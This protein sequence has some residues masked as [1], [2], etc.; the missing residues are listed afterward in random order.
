VRINKT[1]ISALLLTLPLLNGYAQSPKPD[2]ELFAK[3]AVKMPLHMA[4]PKLD[5]KEPDVRMYRSRLRDAAANGRMF[6]GHYRAA[7]WG[8]GS[9]C[10][11]FSIID[12][13]T[14]EVYHFPGTISSDNEVGERL[15]FR[16]DSRA[17]HT[18]GSINEGDSA[19]RWYVWNGK[20]FKLI[21]E[22]PSHFEVIDPN[23]SQN[24]R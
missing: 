7:V 20:E 22:K 1:L 15:T 10:I 5:F 4:T 21:S 17:V 12:V 9:G 2:A 23:S 16:K 3:Y 24:E 14:G 8:C 6:A 19:D 18:I 13:E 11:V